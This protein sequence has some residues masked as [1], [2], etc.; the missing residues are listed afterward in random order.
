MQRR[1]FLTLFF[2]IFAAITGVGLVVPLLP[3]LAEQM[4]AGGVLTGM[5]FGSF[6][7]SRSLLLPYF[8]RRS[9]IKGRKPYIVAGLFIYAA[10]SIAFILAQSVWAVVIVRFFQ[11]MASAMILPVTQAYIGD[12]TPQGQEG[13]IMGLF[14]VSMYLSLTLGPV[15]GGVVNDHFGLTTA[16]AAMGALALLATVAAQVWLPSVENEPRRPG[17]T[18]PMPYKE[19]VLHPRVVGVS[20]FYMV[21]MLCIGVV[22]AFLPVTATVEYGLSSSRIGIVIALGVFVAGLLQTHMG[23]MADRFGKRGF[24]VFGGLLITGVMFSFPR[25]EGFWGL[26]VVNSVFGIGGGAAVPALMAIAVVE[27]ARL[28]SMGSVM[29]LVTLGHSMGM[30]IGS[31][32]GGLIKDLMSLDQAYPAGGVCML[33]GLVYFLWATRE[34]AIPEKK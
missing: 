7:L 22:W 13:R 34:G 5:I 8:G 14:N 9:D 19:L 24:V 33:I 20:V 17:S 26:A 23:S 12:I 6:S 29:S 16:F 3:P 27:G 4:G 32:L 15:L 1:V 2:S 18:V 31:V 30:L 10:L 28:K 21:Y 11:G 25:V